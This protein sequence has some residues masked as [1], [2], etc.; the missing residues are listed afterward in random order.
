MKLIMTIFFTLILAL[1]AL[2]EDKPPADA[3]T[4]KTGEATTTPQGADPCDGDRSSGGVKGG[5]TREGG[6]APDTA[7]GN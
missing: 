6:G 3:A 2:A 5:T 1:P 7:T 4:P